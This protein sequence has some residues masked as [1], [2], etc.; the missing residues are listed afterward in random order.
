LRPAPMLRPSSRRWRSSDG[1]SLVPFVRLLD[2]TI[3]LLCLIAAWLAAALLLVSLGLVG[4]SVVMRYFMNRPIPWVDE[5]VGYLLVGLVMLAAADA[6]KRGEHIAVDLVTSRLGPRGRRLSLA[7]GQIA[8]FVVGIALAIGG[9]QTAAFS[10][11]L[12]IYSTGYLA[13]PIHLPQLLVP[14]GG[15]LLALAAL[16]GLMRMAVGAS[17][18]TGDGGDGH[19][20]PPGPRL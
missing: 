5:L 19:P 8:V 4:Y 10:K 2:R 16:A 18:T 11:L 20:L 15:G 17:P 3:G 13:V 12:G 9:W 6:L 14:A 7:F 1:S